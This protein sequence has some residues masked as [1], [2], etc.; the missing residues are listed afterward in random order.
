MAVPSSPSPARWLRSCAALFALIGFLCSA[1][2]ASAAGP[3]P[4]LHR[5]F[6][7]VIDP[8]HGGT[9]EGCASHDGGVHEK[10]VTLELARE[11]KQRLE[12]LLPHARVVL[13]R[14]QDVTMTLADRV[15]FANETKADLFLSIHANA[16][17]ERNQV[18]YETYLLDLQAS[19][20][21]AARTAQRENDEGFAT[22]KSVSAVDSMVRELALVANRKRA[23]YY[24][25]ALQT[26]QGTRFPNR[27]DRGVRQAPFDVLMGTRMPAV[28]HEVGFLDHPEEGQLLRSDVGRA[29][30]VNGMAQATVDYYRDVQRRQ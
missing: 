26:H 17:P 23:A 1:G 9:N 27:L 3:K 20:L 28:L 22:P 11:L 2:F 5:D 19:N 29:E 14:D 15:A 8:G 6:V 16:S 12:D 13:T 25:R 24:A 7:V 18:G 21:E 10:E 4:V 30:L